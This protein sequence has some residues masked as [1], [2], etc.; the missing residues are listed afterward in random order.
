[1]TINGELRNTLLSHQFLEIGPHRVGALGENVRAS[2]EDLVQDL[3]SLIRGADFV[4]VGVH[5]CPPHSGVFPVFDDGVHLA[6]DVLDRFADPRQQRFEAI[7]VARPDI[8]PG[9]K[10]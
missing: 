5:Q 7:E 9:A 1:M 4:S 3:H 6:T 8:A 2:V 10:R